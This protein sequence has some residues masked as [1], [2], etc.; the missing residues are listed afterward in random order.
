MLIP[1]RLYLCSTLCIITNKT[2]YILNYLVT[3][4]PLNLRRTYSF[5][6]QGQFAIWIKRKYTRE[7]HPM[8]FSRKLASKHLLLTNIFSWQINGKLKMYCA[9]SLKKPNWEIICT[10]ASVTAVTCYVTLTNRHFTFLI[11]TFKSFIMRGLTRL[12]LVIFIL[13]TILKK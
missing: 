10:V 8:M 7:R 13:K 4:L 3:M 6:F 11:H 12:Y 5:T 9:V 2:A 1:T